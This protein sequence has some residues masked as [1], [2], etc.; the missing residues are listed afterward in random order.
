MTKRFAPLALALCISG[1][2]TLAPTYQRPAAPVAAS[3][4]E[5][6]GS[7]ASEAA[8]SIGWERFF[9]DARLRELIGLAL[10]NNR[11]LRVAILNIEQARA[12]FRVRRADVL[13]TVGLGA[14]ASRTPGPD[15]SINSHYSA[16]LVVSARPINCFRRASVK[17][18]S[19]AILA[20]AWFDA[21]LPASAKLA[22][23]GAA[24]RW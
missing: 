9:V 12:Q 14:S 18:R 7:A 11:D 19:Q 17:K 2:M 23:T 1:C 6:A 20:A 8:A 21:A 15:D 4:P 16:G 24:G 3:Y 10:Q 13:P 5:L 22:A